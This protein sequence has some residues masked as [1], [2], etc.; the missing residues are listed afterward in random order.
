MI[1]FS[2]FIR[3]GVSSAAKS[4]GKDATASLVD[5]VARHYARI[6]RERDL[7]E[8]ALLDITKMPAER[9]PGIAMRAL[10]RAEE[11]RD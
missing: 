11:T 4:L 6:A 5:G 3:Q 1:D 7:Y 2:K 8:A 10:K 9:G